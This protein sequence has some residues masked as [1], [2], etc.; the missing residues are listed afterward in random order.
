MPKQP[1]KQSQGVSPT[2]AIRVAGGTAP[3]VPADAGNEPQAMQR[4][5][6]FLLPLLSASISAIWGGVLQALLQKQVATF[7]GASNAGQAAVLGTVLTIAAIMSV[8]STPVV[9]RLSDR[10]RIRFLGRRNI[11]IIGG[12]VAGT[13]AMVFTGLSTSVVAVTIAW[14]IAI[15]P[16]NGVQGAASAVVPERV[17]IAVR[18]RL[19]GY[20]GVA[21]LVGVGIGATV[22]SL[23][24]NFPVAY[25]AL[26]VQ[27]IVIGAIFAFL[28]KDVVPAPIVKGAPAAKSELMNFR[29]NADFWWVFLGRFLAFVGYNLATGLQIYALRDHFHVGGGTTAGAS[30]ANPIIVGTSTL[31]LIVSSITGGI[32]ADK[33]GRLK[34]F[35]VGAS[36]VFIPAGLVLG[37]TGGLAG[38]IAGFGLLGFAFGAYISVDGAL[39]T[40]VLP[41]LQNAGRDLGI[42]NIANAGPQVIAP[43]LAGSLVATLGYPAL[44]LGTVVAATLASIAVLRVRS[45]R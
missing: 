4:R 21:A 8:V 7:S 27:L 20:Q 33:F 38:A 37:F 29:K 17:P 28:T 43:I 13:I 1:V 36:V 45:V 6:W 42:L 41:N 12:A 9:G 30:A 44:F 34:P 16:L 15:I 31:L 40:R 19:S 26:G 2:Q 39:I 18:A 5:L 35:V 24:N 14:S 11:W 23:S 3:S 32:L 10:T 22:G 25:T